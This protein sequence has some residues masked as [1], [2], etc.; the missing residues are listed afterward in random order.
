MQSINNHTLS[1]P[2]Q[3]AQIQQQQEVTNN[4]NKLMIQ[5]S[6]LEQEMYSQRTD[7]QTKYQ[8]IVTKIDNI[9]NELTN[10]INQLQQSSRQ[11]YQQLLEELKSQREQNIQMLQA[12]ALRQQG[13]KQQQFYGHKQNLSDNQYDYIDLQE[14][15]LLEELQTLDSY[16]QQKQDIHDPIPVS[17]RIQVNY[18]SPT[19]HQRISSNYNS[20][21]QQKQHTPLQSTQY[22]QNAPQMQYL[23]QLRQNYGTIELPQNIN[24]EQQQNSYLSAPQ[25][26]KRQSAR[27]QGNYSYGEFQNKSPILITNEEQVVEQRNSYYP[28]NA[29]SQP[30][31]QLSIKQQGHQLKYSDNFQGALPIHKHKP[32]FDQQITNKSRITEPNQEKQPINQID[33]GYQ[34]LLTQQ[35]PNRRIIINN[36][37]VRF[38]KK[39]EFLI[40]LI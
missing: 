24:T 33:Q 35:T 6:E 31:Q 36:N 39:K 14:Q 11:D 15:Q 30:D 21:Q 13:N 40:Y 7:T 34:I 26:S 28:I 5:Y 3:Q 2:R 29:S 9:Y 23:N 27:G 22:S 37:Q 20:I 17:S 4:Y 25:Y 1:T 10:N 12:I 16:K 19:S 38:I 18:L 8:S 32:I